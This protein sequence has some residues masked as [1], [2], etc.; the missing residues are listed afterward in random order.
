MHP[1]ENYSSLLGSFARGKR[2]GEKQNEKQILPLNGRMTT[3]MG[4]G[5]NAS[6][7]DTLEGLCLMVS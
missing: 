2:E 1:R 3:K 7:L 5:W 6:M 4:A